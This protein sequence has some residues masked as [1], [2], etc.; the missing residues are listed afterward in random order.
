M[1]TK[2][3]KPSRAITPISDAFRTKYNIQSTRDLSLIHI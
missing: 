3:F 2:E 1:T